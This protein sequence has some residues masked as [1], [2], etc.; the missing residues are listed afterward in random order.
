[1]R[2]KAERRE[3]VLAHPVL[4][5]GVCAA[6]WGV[7]SATFFVI[8]GLLAPTHASVLVGVLACLASG[9][10]VGPIFYLLFRSSMRRQ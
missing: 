1:M 6:Y 7:F 4:G 9:L 5:S 3:W 8:R 10:V 2:S